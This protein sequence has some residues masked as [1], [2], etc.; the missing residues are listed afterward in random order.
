V[1]SSN[2][3]DQIN[4]NTQAI[5][6]NTQA[7]NTNTQ[8]INTNTQAINTQAINTQAIKI[9]TLLTFSLASNV[10]RDMHT[11]IASCSSLHANAIAPA[12][13]LSPS[14]DVNSVRGEP[15]LVC[16]LVSLCNNTAR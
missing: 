13:A 14:V 10:S 8:A 4:T 11:S 5:N 16:N 9:Q 7:I 2:R 3:P 12:A 1:A 15:F 6:T